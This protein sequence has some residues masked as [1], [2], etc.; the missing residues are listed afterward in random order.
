MSGSHVER[1]Y[2]DHWELWDGDTEK[3]GMILATFDGAKEAE[4]R[5]AFDSLKKRSGRNRLS[6]V[7][8]YAVIW[9]DDDE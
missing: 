6:L 7:R 3:G 2:L 8:R 1:V 4:A 9:I 5:H